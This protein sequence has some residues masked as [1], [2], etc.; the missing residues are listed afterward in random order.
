MTDVRWLRGGLGAA[1]VLG[2]LWPAGASAHERSEP[3]PLRI[4]QAERAL[5]THIRYR[6]AF[7]HILRTRRP[8][9]LGAPG[10][11]LATEK[12]AIDRSDAPSAKQLLRRL[13]DE[14]RQFAT[15]R[16]WIRRRHDEMRPTFVSHTARYD[17]ARGD[18]LS[19][20]Y[21]AYARGCRADEDAYDQGW[22]ALLR[23]RQTLG[24]MVATYRPTHVLVV[25][26][27]WRVDQHE[28][29]HDTAK[30]LER[31]RRAARAEAHGDFRPLVAM[32]TWPSNWAWGPLG[33]VASYFTKANDADEVGMLWVNL[34]VHRVI[35]PVTKRAQLP[36]V[37][38]GHSFGA[39][40]LTRALVSRPLIDC[41][42]QC[43][44]D[45]PVDLMIALQG[46]FDFE[47]F[48]PGEGMEG[49]PYSRLPY[50]SGTQWV[51]TYSGRDYANMVSRAVTGSLHVG[52]R[53]A[54]WRSA[55][56]PCLVER[57]RVNCDGSSWHSLNPAGPPGRKRVLYLDATRVLP[58]HSAI[59]TPGVGRLLMAAIRRFAP[60]G[61]PPGTVPG[62]GRPP[63]EDLS[64]HR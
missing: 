57:A 12:A 25:C 56:Y 19:V 62:I 54:W 23:L 3:V 41:S 28:G 7:H 55:R 27:G 60:A 64:G 42:E 9:Q 58:G 16:S 2:A 39:R 29:I 36:V 8:P 49:A 33:E 51:L 10:I 34:L 50:T 32:I 20:V 59:F 45:S 17:G 63:R 15:Y 4:R 22:R 31:M 5:G 30:V 43:Q 13:H 46:A 44:R 24:E 38:I 61:S 40:I 6:Q 18:S 48:V 52:S 26:M 21:S 35:A 53:L 37:A 1:L 47:R 14:A 11:V